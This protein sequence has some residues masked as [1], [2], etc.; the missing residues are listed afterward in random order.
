MS[1]CKFYK[2]CKLYRISSDTCNIN[3]GMYYDDLERPAGCYRKMENK[4]SN[5]Q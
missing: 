5:K 1:R 3:G 4:E 2:K